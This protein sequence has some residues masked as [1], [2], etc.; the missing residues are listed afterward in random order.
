M[1][2]AR[3]NALTEATSLDDTDWLVAEVGDSEARKVS[4]A[5]LATAVLGYELDYVQKTTDTTISA[6]SE[7]TA[8]TVVTANAVSFDGSTRVAIEFFS[9]YVAPGATG[10]S[11][12]VICLYDGSSSVGFLATTRWTTRLRLTEA[13]R[14]CSSEYF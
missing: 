10:G 6:T 2:D 7:A 11:S 12:I 9:P 4:V 14:A 13:P 1:A 3:I 8:T 5:T